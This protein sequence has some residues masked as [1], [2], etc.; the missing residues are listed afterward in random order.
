M[1]FTLNQIDELRERT[2]VN[3]TDAK[4]ALENCNGDMLEAIVYLE[5]NKK[6]RASKTKATGA[7]FPD[8]ISELLRK[9]SLTRF[10]MRKQEKIILNISVNMLVL[11][12]LITIPLIELVA[13]ALLIAILTGHR[14]K[15]ESSSTDTTKINEALDRVSETVDH[16]KVKFSNSITVNAKDSAE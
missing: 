12:G 2:G 14:F 4:E 3:Y 11:F 13:I 10:V 15:F 16:A 9:G 7:S 6:A 5:K 8:K 1:S